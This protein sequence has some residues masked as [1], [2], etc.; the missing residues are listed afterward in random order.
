MRRYPLESYLRHAELFGPE[1]VLETAA[2]DLTSRELAQ[3]QAFIESRERT[4]RWRNGRWEERPERALR[5]CAHCGLDLPRAARANQRYHG[6]C[7]STAAS[8]RARGTDSGRGERNH[9]AP[10]QTPLRR[11]AGAAHER[12]STR[13]AASPRPLEGA[14]T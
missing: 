13:P 1:L 5:R 2:G 14:L 6:H 11:P 7:K 4:H 10:A 12:E 8:R 9:R 3:L